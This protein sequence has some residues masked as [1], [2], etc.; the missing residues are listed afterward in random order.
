MQGSL[1][2][3]V[4]TRIQRGVQM[5][6]NARR[7]S[8]I[9]FALVLTHGIPV[10]A[11]AIKA[12]TDHTKKNSS[13]PVSPPPPAPSADAPQSGLAEI[14]VTAE[15]RSANLQRVPLAV[16]ALTE[17]DLNN[18]QIK[19]TIDAVKFVP[20]LVSSTSSGQQPGAASYFLR[21]I[22]STDSI[23]TIDPPVG[24]YEDDIYIARQALNNVQAFDVDR[25]EVLRGPQG[26]L[27]GKNTTGG[28]INVISKRPSQEMFVNASVEYGE[29]N[30]A[31]LRATINL[32]VNDDLALMAS[33][34]F[35]RSDG[36]YHSRSA[37]GDFGG[38]DNYGIRLSAEYKPNSDVDWFFY[39]ERV[40]LRGLSI[41]IP[42]NP[43]VSATKGRAATI[44]DSYSTL[45]LERPECYRGDSPFAW[46][47]NG[48][49]GAQTTG[50]NITSNL[51]VRLSD[52]F[53]LG[54]IS[55]YRH[56][57][58]D[59]S[60][61][62][63]GNTT[64][65]VLPTYILTN[66]GNFNQ[67]SQELKLTGSILN[68]RVDIVGGLFYF[69]ERNDTQI[70]S[71][72]KYPALFGPALT[73]VSRSHLHNKLDSYA[74]YLQLDTHL[75]D[76]LTLV[77]AGRITHDD[78]RVGVVFTALQPAGGVSFTTAD[79]PTDQIRSTRFTPKAALQYQ[80]T[81]NIMA[82]A[83]A[84]N[85]FKSGGWNGRASTASGFQPFY[86]E[87]VWSYEIGARVELFDHRLRLNGTLFHADYKNLQISA[88]VANSTPRV[89]ATQN[90]GD[91]R[92]QGFEL[93]SNAQLARGLFAYLGLGLQNAKFTRVTPEAA[94]AG[95]SLTSKVTSAPPSTINGGI[96]YEL[97]LNGGYKLTFDVNVQHIPTY[98]SS[99]TVTTV[100]PAYNPVSASVGLMTPDDRFGATLVCQNCF[101]KPYIETPG[102]AT[103][104]L[105]ILP[106]V[107]V[108][109]SAKFH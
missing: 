46:E 5:H 17:N 88:I 21:G 78:K 44:F 107:G 59:Y 93:E 80:F 3:L 50:D 79:I 100:T 31:D 1:V 64:F 52:T 33:G 27:F 20:N 55:G 73:D 56:T 89:F 97:A 26:T 61:D 22:G 65:S 71:T 11:Q 13:V 23:Q 76:K 4:E 70:M 2:H 98:N 41:V 24:A 66:E 47:K 58:Q 75:T 54:V 37:S 83:S 86:D 51:R 7:A 8:R 101:R 38:T 92:V 69:R 12:S 53:S 74:A 77:T 87:T 39:G 90:A 34:F 60:A 35:Q 19:S 91:S 32:P 99:I 48:C 96:N 72:Y 49:Y 16:T 102:G 6:T 85:G 104:A 109:L 63:Q 42:S 9:A 105:G 82:Y 67:L 18:R 106:Y 40:R 95:F 28:A 103:N 68:G 14:V 30:T 108:R 36:Y 25:V 81:P 57:D 10:E 15:R 45:N 62:F 29:R 94:A 43:A 84:T